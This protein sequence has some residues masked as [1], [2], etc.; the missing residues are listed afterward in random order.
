MRQDPFSLCSVEREIG[1]LETYGYG[2]T[3]Q[4]LGEGT[5]LGGGVTFGCRFSFEHATH[6]G[7]RLMK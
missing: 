7:L 4:L 2:S 1:E 5:L 3:V 6:T